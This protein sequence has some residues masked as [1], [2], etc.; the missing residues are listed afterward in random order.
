MELRIYPSPRVEEY[1]TYYP[2]RLIAV[3]TG[4]SDLSAC[5]ETKPDPAA[6]VTKYSLL[7]L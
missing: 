3:P 7:D 1:L 6:F 4:A 5:S 2:C